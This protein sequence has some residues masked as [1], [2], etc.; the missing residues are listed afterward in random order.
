MPTKYTYLLVDFF[1]FVFPFILSFHP[2]SKFYKE[3]KHFVLPCL[4][5]ASFFIIWD[6]LFTFLQV[7][8]FNPNY[9]LGIYFFNL[10]IEELLFFICIPYACVFTYHLIKLFL[11]VSKYNKQALFFSWSLILF[12]LVTAALNIL[13]LYTSVTFILMAVCLSWLALKKAAFL[14]NFYLTYLFILIPFFISN[15]I[16][17]GSFINEPVVIYNDAQNLGIRMLTIPFEDT[18]YGMLLML[19]N[20]ALLE[21]SVFKKKI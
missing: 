9:V 5:T 1:C 19:M 3:L 4:L 13:K 20:V 10:P 21:S 2:K 6:M 18:F 17:T 14:A 12:L 11:D 8:S 7:W 16:L 15:G